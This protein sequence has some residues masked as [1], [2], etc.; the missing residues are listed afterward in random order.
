[1]SVEFGQREYPHRP[2]GGPRA[3]RLLIVGL[4]TIMFAYIVGAIILAPR[5]LPTRPG[6]PTTTADSRVELTG[7]AFQSP[8]PHLRVAGKSKREPVRTVFVL[9]DP[10]Q[11]PQSFD[12]RTVRLAGRL[13]VVDG[14][15]VLTLETPGAAARTATAGMPTDAARGTA[16]VGATT[17]DESR[18]APRAAETPD[19]PAAADVDPAERARLAP[20]PLDLG[21]IRVTGT[22]GYL[23]ASA[24]TPRVAVLRAAEAGEVAA[25]VLMSDGRGPL[26]AA[27]V[28]GESA[29]APGTRVEVRGRLERWGDVLWIGVRADGLR[30]T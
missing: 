16:A 2:T 3:A 23:T 22:L 20:P 8:Y 27:H 10:A 14:L 4:P 30:R 26:D 21:E 29:L 11:F 13:Q 9:G 15:H 19:A 25:Y 17:A 24:A 12:G 1:M 6:E 18:A 28:G 5:S 7:L